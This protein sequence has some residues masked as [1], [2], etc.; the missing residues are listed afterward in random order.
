M[1][2]C[3]LDVAM[4]SSYLY[5]S[6]AE[7]NRLMS[8]PVAT[9]K[10]ALRETLGRFV[11]RPLKVAIEAG[12]QTAWLYE[13][14]NEMGAEVTVVNP[15]K[16]K[17][18]A[19]SRR[20]TDKVD[21]K[22]LCELLRLDGLPRP[23]HMPCRRTRELRGLLAARRKL[24]SARTKLCNV[25]RGLMRQEG[26]RLP[27][28]ALSARV[29]WDRL[30]VREYAHGHLRPILGAYYLSFQ[31]LTE[32]LKDLDTELGKYERQDSRAMR[33]QTMPGVGRIASLTFLAAVDEVERFSSSR[34]LV[35]YS[36]LCP[37]VRS[38]GERTEYGPISREGRS[39]LRAVW[40]QV[41]HRVAHDGRAATRSLRAWF[42][43]V[44]GRRGKKTATVA[45]TR[46]LLTIAYHLLKHEQ[47]YDPARLRRAA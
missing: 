20:K 46:K 5:V 35:S 43:R 18:I 12:N 31:A 44:A 27:A 33:L 15:T 29:G 24:V 40:V 21:A 22:V 41:A 39:E 32:S 8:G 26:I 47:D 45:L 4:V 10:G 14:L 36:G 13:A 37:V 6:D 34:K 23:V 42:W 19:E 30:L 3:G 1:V 16:V 28:R 7:G 25:V 2:Y 9:D 17:L 11:K 38:S